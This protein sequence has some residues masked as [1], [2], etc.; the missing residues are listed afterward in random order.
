MHKGY[1]AK[2][3]LAG[4]RAIERPGNFPADRARV[5]ERKLGKHVVRMLVVDQRLTVIGFAGLEKLG[6]SRMRRGERLGGKHL[7][8]QDPAAPEL[9]LL[10][11]HQPVDRLRLAFAARPTLLV[12]IGKDY[13]VRHQVPGSHRLHPRMP[14]GRSGLPS[15]A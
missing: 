2:C 6:K 3:W 9:V 13:A 11:Q 12:V 7:T 1:R 15:R 10:H 4:G 14:G 5:V 8:K